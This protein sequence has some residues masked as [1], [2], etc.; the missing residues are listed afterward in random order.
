MQKEKTLGITKEVPAQNI[1]P[2]HIGENRSEALQQ[3][4]RN[5][6]VIKKTKKHS[7]TTLPNL[8]LHLA[9]LEFLWVLSARMKFDFSN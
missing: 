6:L 4:H 2:Q 1:A 3:G 5:L 9:V 8:K 7:K